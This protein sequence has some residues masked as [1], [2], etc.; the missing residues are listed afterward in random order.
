MRQSHKHPFVWQ[1]NIR[2]DIPVYEMDVNINDPAFSQKA[3]DIL[4]QLIDSVRD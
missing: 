2:N 1:A 4:L 3:V